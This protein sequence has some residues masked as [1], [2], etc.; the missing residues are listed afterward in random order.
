MSQIAFPDSCAWRRR[1]L[2]GASAWLE[3]SFLRYV[4]VRRRPMM[5]SGERRFA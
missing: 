3:S 5:A 4:E 1:R 2:G